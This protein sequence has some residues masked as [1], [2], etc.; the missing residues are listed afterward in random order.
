MKGLVNIMGKIFNALEKAD[1]KNSQPAFVKVRSKDA[2]QAKKPLETVVPLM[3]SNH[4]R[5][6]NQMDK[7]LVVYHTPRSVEAELFK[8]LRTN[9]LF[10]STGV[11]PKSILVTS[12][13]PG[14]GKSFVSANLAISIAQGVEEHVLLIDGDIRRPTLHSRFGFKK[15][16]GLSEYLASGENVA[17]VL[18]KTSIDKLTLLPAGDPPA[19]PT[20]LISSK[21][22]KELLGEVKSRYNDRYI[23]IDS[24]PPA[25]ASETNAIAKYV[26]GII[27]VVSAGKTPSNAIA[28]TI[29]RIG[30]EKLIGI[31]LNQADRSL[32]KFYGYKKS[33]Y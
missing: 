28:E 21:K 9:I 11:P 32:K 13:L 23:L 8:M 17:E 10:P 30:K 33:Y 14:D 18:L 29:E 3:N 12:A 5:Y 24:P 31:V 20:E 1:K 4:E 19:R 27:I 22:M 7:T 15:V 26:D 2:R 16:N 6:P 25:M